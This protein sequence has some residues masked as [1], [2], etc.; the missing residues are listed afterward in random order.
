MPVT[1]LGPLGIKLNPCRLDGLVARLVD[2]NQIHLV[3]R[4]KAGE[5]KA[6]SDPLSQSGALRRIRN[7][8]RR[9]GDPHESIG[10]LIFFVLQ[11][12]GADAVVVNRSLCSFPERVA[13]KEGAQQVVQIEVDPMSIDP[14]KSRRPNG[15]S[16]SHG[17]GS[18]FVVRA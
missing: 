14:I 4:A 17:M 3:R 9:S 10:Y 1:R 8:S 7:G 5:L 11:R 12:R 16:L 18:S 13:S 15:S 2:A 6:E